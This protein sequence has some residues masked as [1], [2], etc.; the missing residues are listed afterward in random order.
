ML[1]YGLLALALAYHLWACWRENQQSPPGKLI[2][3]GGYRLHLYESG[4][5][6]AGQPTIVFDPSLGGLEGYLLID[7]IAKFARVCVY[8]RAGYGWSQ[9]SPY[10]RTSGVIAQELDDLLTRADIDPPYLLVGESFG[11]YNM[12][13]YAHSFPEK[14][15]GLVLTDGLH[16]S[17]MLRMPV[18][19]RLLKAFFTSGFW[20]STVGSSLGLVRVLNAVGVFQ[21][22]KPELRQFS[23]IQ[24]KSVFRSFCRPKHWITMSR[25]IMDLHTS[26]LQLRDAEDL[27]TLPVVNVKAANFFKPS[28]ISGILPLGAADRLRDRMH[29]DLMQLSEQ[30]IQLQAHHS[31]HFV[32]VDEPDVILK[33]IKICLVR[34]TSPLRLHYPQILASFSLKPGKTDSPEIVCGDDSTSVD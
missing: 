1:E 31:S 5:A 13:L 25:E 20:M 10:P 9:H 7:E 34:S 30:C 6:K 33:A 12:R 28:L 22:L 14:V 8:D 3:V 29:A 27:G 23:D 4:I 26:S 21:L 17:G 18:S 24:R 11:S 16:E 32:W 15:A 19:L 2:D